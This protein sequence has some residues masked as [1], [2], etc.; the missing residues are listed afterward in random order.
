MD[1]CLRLGGPLDGHQA[2]HEQ[3]PRRRRRRLRERSPN[4]FL[5]SLDGLVAVSRVEVL[6]LH[7]VQLALR[8]LL[9]GLEQAL[10][11][12]ARPVLLPDLRGQPEELGDVR[13]SSAGLE[14]LALVDLAAAPG[15]ELLHVSSEGLPILAVWERGELGASL[16]FLHGGLP[17]HRC[18]LILLVPL[19]CG[20]EVL[21]IQLLR[22]V[23]LRRRHLAGGL[24]RPLLVEVLDEVGVFVLVAAVLAY[25]IASFLG[26]REPFE[27]NVELRVPVPGQLWGPVA[28]APAAL[29]HVVRAVRPPLQLHHVLELPVR[30][31]RVRHLADFHGVLRLDH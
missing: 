5:R 14:Q 11:P 20:G 22:L 7:K 17:L 9:D 24:C 21:L 8:L 23:L 16:Q 19:V 15:V 27:D 31:G 3:W 25:E 26:V 4:R 29:A 12:V 10:H 6:E 28:D 30:L 18:G 2:S 13:V 1:R